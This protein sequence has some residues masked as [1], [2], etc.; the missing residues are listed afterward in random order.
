MVA[1]RSGL[2]T[3][4]NLRTLLRRDTGLTPTEYR[5]RFGHD[6]GRRPDLAQGTPDHAQRHDEVTG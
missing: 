3:A 4:T 1:R 6:A 2:G 5:R